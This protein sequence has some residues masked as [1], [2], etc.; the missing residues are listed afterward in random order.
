M[1]NPDAHSTSAARATAQARDNEGQAF[2]KQ[3]KW[4]EA[5]AAFRAA[6]EK[7]PE[8]SGAWYMIGTTEVAKNGAVPCEAAHDPLKRCLELD[9]DNAGAHCALGGVLLRV[10]E[11]DVRAEEHF[12]AALPRWVPAH[13]GLAE[14]F[15]ERG[16][17]DGA[18]REMLA[19]VRKGDP[20]GNG[21]AYLAELLERK[22]AGLAAKPNPEAK[23]RFPLPVARAPRSRAPSC[24]WISVLMLRRPP[25]S[26]RAR[27]GAGAL[28]QGRG[29]VQAGQV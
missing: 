11:D 25:R 19:C 21:K 26:W 23:A 5:L 27:N 18:I 17:L 12:R 9:P 15:Q 3:G 16:D 29:V 1:L 7:D 4:D 14:I 13:R 22:K 10:R 24:D 2:F 20:G 6:V 28:R 8:M